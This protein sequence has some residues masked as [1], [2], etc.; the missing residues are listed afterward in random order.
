MEEGE[1]PG[2][3]G[4]GARYVTEFMRASNRAIGYPEFGMVVS[5]VAGEQRVEVHALSS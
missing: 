3:P 2:K 1:R 5:I 4:I